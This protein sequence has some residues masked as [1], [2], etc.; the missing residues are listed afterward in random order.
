MR[1]ILLERGDFVLS[2]VETNEK[3][4]LSCCRDNIVAG[5]SMTVRVLLCTSSR[6]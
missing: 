2:I 3:R 4:D 5:A 6:F 1:W